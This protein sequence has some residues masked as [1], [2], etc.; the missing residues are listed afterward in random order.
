MPRK[1]WPIEIH[2]M[3]TILDDG[4]KVKD[5]DVKE[6][7]VFILIELKKLNIQAQLITEEEIENDS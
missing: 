7:L 2:G 3:D 5:L 6:L 1:Q 4:I